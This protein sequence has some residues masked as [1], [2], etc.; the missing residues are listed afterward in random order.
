MSARM[1]LLISVL[2]PAAAGACGHQRWAV[3]TGT[4]HEAR[5]VNLSYSV[6]TTVENLDALSRPSRLPAT[7]RVKPVELSVYLIK[8]TLVE[9]KRARDGDYRL[10][11][12]GRD[13]NTLVAAIPAPNCVGSASPFASGVSNARREFNARFKASTA[14]RRAHTPVTVKGVGFFDERRRQTGMAPNSI[15]LHPVIDIR[16]GG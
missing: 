5:E 8:A 13:G 6:P 3:K 7:H 1:L 12:K 2:L 4:D 9:Y 11:L 15:E 14:F 10:V 16:F